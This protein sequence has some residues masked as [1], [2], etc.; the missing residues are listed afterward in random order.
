MALGLGH[1]LIEDPVPFPVGKLVG[2]EPGA[3]MAVE[4]GVGPQV[5]AVGRE[6]QALGVQRQGAGE[7]GL[8]RHA[9]ALA[10]PGLSVT[11]ARALTPV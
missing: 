4:R 5:M 8:V 10:R 11:R 9:T 1:D 6:M 3:D 2:F 7:K